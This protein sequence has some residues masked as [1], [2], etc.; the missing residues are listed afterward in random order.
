MSSKEKECKWTF[1]EQLDCAQE[2]GP[3]NAMAQ[4]FKKSPYPSLIRESI[5]NSLDA[6]LDSNQPVVMQYQFISMNSSEYPELF[7][8]KDHIQGCLDYYSENGNA[9]AIYDPMI[10]KFEDKDFNSQMGYIKIS[11]FNTKGMEYE[12]NKTNSPFY[13]FVRS[14]GVSAKD[15]QSKGGSFGFGKAAYYLISPISTILVSTCTNEG[16]KFF[17]GI[18]SLCTHMVNGKKYANVG[19]YDDNGG[20]P[21]TDESHIPEEFIR[22]IPGTDINILGFNI[23]EKK[24]A[25]KEMVEAVLWNFWFAIY[26]NKLI[27]II[28][29][30]TISSDNLEQLINE[31]FSE[32]SSPKTNPKPFFEAVKNIA[33]NRK[34]FRFEKN[35]E[36]LGH[37][38]FYLN[39]EKGGLDRIT[40]MRSP[41]M[42]VESKG[43]RSHNG[44]FAVFHCDGKSGDDILRNMENPAHDEW[45]PANW[46][47]H[48]QT[49]LKGKEAYEELE[50]FV[51]ECIQQ[52]FS[53]DDQTIINIKG[54][55]EFLYIPTSCDEDDDLESESL[56]STPT[57]EIKDDGTAPTTDI[58]S[59]DGNPTINSPDNDKP[60]GA[61]F[62]TPKPQK[63]SNGGGG[64]RTGNGKSKPKTKGGNPHPGDSSQE[65]KPDNS[66]KEGTYVEKIDVGYRTF[67]QVEDGIV[68][69]YI[70]IHSDQAFSN[71]RLSFNSVGEDSNE[72]LTIASSN[73]G[74]VTERFVEKLEIPVGTKR[75]KVKF[76]DDMKHAIDLSAEVVHG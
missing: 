55:E 17:E 2:M 44:Y 52:V 51:N 49:C 12:K 31:Y 58:V 71:A 29:D 4:N 13:A 48:G 30:K 25:V 32:N 50:K 10:E 6:V 14:T 76:T 46:K 69:H 59:G 22:K 18:T 9:K 20:M 7:S 62:I 41:K 73:E 70:C 61:L 40:Y 16:S 47:D 45:K 38:S 35:L 68:Y 57:G 42:L 27:V 60:T 39:K 67:S 28:D 74:V 75:I 33:D 65:K 15:G 36:I 1:A 56:I 26:S 63:A 19:Y 72:M 23:K 34:F 3:N 54:L 53:K 64:L 21:I 66:G 37:C 43:R 11:D 8:L 24:S 5:Q